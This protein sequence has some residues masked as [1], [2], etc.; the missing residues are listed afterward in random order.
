MS[1][2]KT[3]SKTMVCENVLGLCVLER[4]KELTYACVSYYFYPIFD[5][6]VYTIDR[7]KNWA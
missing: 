6:I 3:E 2:K 1:V 4:E 5:T 7:K